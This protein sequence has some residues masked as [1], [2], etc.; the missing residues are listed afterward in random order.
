MYKNNI[1]MPNYD[2][3]ILNLINSILKHYNVK[4]KYN[5]LKEIDEKLTH[6]YKNVVLIILDGMG[7]HIFNKITPNGFFMKNHIDKITSVCPST[8][9][10]AMTTYY[11]GKPPIE[12][13]WIA[14]S[15]YF[16][17]QER[18]VELLRN[19]YSYTFDEVNKDRFDIYDLVKYKSIYEQI[20]EASK[21]VNAYEILPTP[22]GSRTQRNVKA[23]TTKQ[24]CDAVEKICKNEDKNFILA[25]N[26]N[27]DVL[28][29]KN[30][31]EAQVVKDFVLKA[32]EDIKDLCENL[33]GTDTLVIIS[34]DHGHID[35]K[36]SIDIFKLKEL[37]ECMTMQASL[38]P[39]AITFWVKANKKE[40]FEK[41]FKERFNNDYI[42]FTKKEFLEKKLLGYGTEHPKIDD[43]IGD[44]IAIAIGNVAIKL[45]NYIASEPLD[46]KAN[47]CGFT[48][49]EMEVP[50]IMKDC[51]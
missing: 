37:Q 11:S 1:I 34:A 49:N 45:D 3:S 7:E 46:K 4:T 21:D 9:T 44:Y 24:L 22:C 51:E 28:L 26:D 25:Y 33:K 8:T 19:R 5:G 15:Q 20:E 10:A 27:P 39:R 2:R 29:H 32:E 40:K 6:D 42:L 13:G 16:K 48:V 31:T 43:F 47:H 36:E 30:G 23:D 17:E 14:M 41:A 12:T 38:E 35:V 18:N 50:L